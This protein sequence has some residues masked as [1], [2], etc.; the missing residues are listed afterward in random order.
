[1]S[2]YLKLFW[3]L[4]TTIVSSRENKQS[5]VSGT[6]LQYKDR[7]MYVMVRSSTE[8]GLTEVDKSG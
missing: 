7:N 1:M 4:R 8:E 6:S 5:N 3:Y 2:Y